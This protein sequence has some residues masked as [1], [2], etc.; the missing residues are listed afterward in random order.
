ML[1]IGGM[2]LPPGSGKT[3]MSIGCAAILLSA[4]YRDL[5]SE[6]QQR[7][8]GRIV[9]GNGCRN[10]TRDFALH[11][12]ASMTNNCFDVAFCDGRLGSNVQIV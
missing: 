11:K 10:L 1:D 12:P 6:L 9:Q 4:G 2:N 7:S 5:L 8:V 3:I